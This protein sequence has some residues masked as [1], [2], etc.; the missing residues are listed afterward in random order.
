[1]CYV[2]VKSNYLHFVTPDD[3]KVIDSEGRE[4]N[5]ILS[6]GKIDYARLGAVLDKSPSVAD[7]KE[8]AGKQSAVKSD[9]PRSA[10]REKLNEL[11][12]LL[13]PLLRWIITSA[14]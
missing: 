7:M 8:L 3:V 1:M 4:H 6:D 14:R 10:L 2:A 11:D 13:Y 9:K 5:F 12:I